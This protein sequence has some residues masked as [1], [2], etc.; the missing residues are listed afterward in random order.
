M[1]PAHTSRA[2]LKNY[3]GEEEN[4]AGSHVERAGT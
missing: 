3:R 1:I 4:R 2:T